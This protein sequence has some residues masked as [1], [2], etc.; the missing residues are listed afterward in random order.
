MKTLQ[1]N[2]LVAVAA[3]CMGCTSRATA[4]LVVESWEMFSR[5]SSTVPDD[6]DVVY[7]QTIQNPLHTTHRAEI[8]SSYASTAYDMGWVIDNAIFDIAMD[9]HL[10]QLDGET[11]SSG[12]IFVIP[13]VDSYITATG[14]FQYAWPSAAIGAADLV[15]LA[16]NEDSGDQ[17]ILGSA[18]GGNFGL[19]PPFGTLEVSDTGLLHAGVT[20]ELIYFARIIHFEPTPPG[21]YGWGSGEIHFEINPV[22]ESATLSLLVLPAALVLRR[23]RWHP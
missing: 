20:Y 13:A 23:C 3:T 5:V 11:M 7:I 16:F 9:H 2:A 6:R 4:E 19:N 21:T 8:G 10:E 18:S 15:M 22:P 17:P 1:K 12:R 14:R